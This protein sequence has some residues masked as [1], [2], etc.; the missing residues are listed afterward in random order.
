MSYNTFIPARTPTDCDISTEI[1]TVGVDFGD[2]YKQTAPDGLN[3]ARGKISVKWS[4]LTISQ[5]RSIDAFFD[6]QYATP[7]WWKP[8]QTTARKLWRCTSWSASYHD[9]AADVSATFEEVFA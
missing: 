2:G 1:R 3:A 7:F 5:C 8:P 6:A 9:T 4:N